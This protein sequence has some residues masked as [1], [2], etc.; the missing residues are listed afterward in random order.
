MRT[1]MF[2]QMQTLPIKY[3]DTHAHG[4]IMSTYTNDT[5][6]I[7]QLIGQRLPQLVQA[8]VSVIGIAFTMLYYSIWLTIVVALSCFL[9]TRL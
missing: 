3:F 8:S 6:A 5:D 7:R 9:C 4:D 2:N 1:D